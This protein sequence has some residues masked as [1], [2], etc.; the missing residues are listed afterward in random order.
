MKAPWGRAKA[1][2]RRD[3]GGGVVI[4]AHARISDDAVYQAAAL[5]LGYPDQQLR[6][7]L[8]LIADALAGT[9]AERHF[10]PVLA[11]LGGGDLA[12]L[13]SFHV[14]EFDLSRRHSLHLSY[15][16]DGDTRRRGAVLA[17][18]KQQYR[19]SGLLVDTG[20]ELPDYLPMVLEFAAHDPQRGRALLNRFRASLELIRL[21]LQADHLPHAGVLVA[22]CARLGG[23]SPDSRAEIQARYASA[24]DAPD[25]PVEFVGLDLVTTVPEG[26]HR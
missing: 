14:Q 16:T 24:P 1:G 25:R 20:G 11:H 15:W 10:V 8:D 22:V 17:E 7:R 5:V 19:D 9:D 3:D 2:V 18:I 4:P 21:E 12:G 13:Q 23:P 26:A 6:D